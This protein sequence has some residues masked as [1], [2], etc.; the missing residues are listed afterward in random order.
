MVQTGLTL[1]AIALLGYLL[2]YAA[3]RANRGLPKGPLELLATLRLEQRRALYLVRIAERTVVIGASEGGMLTVMEL[4]PA[5][6]ASISPGQPRAGFADILG[7]V[8]MTSPPR[9]RQEIPS[10]TQTTASEK[11]PSE[12]N[13]RP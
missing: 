13:T 12:P 3:R 2:V 5:E 1:G 8:L 4:S 7:R 11:A 10:H 9:K 6:L